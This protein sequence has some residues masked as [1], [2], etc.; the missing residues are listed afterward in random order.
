[1]PRLIYIAGEW[2]QTSGKIAV[3]NP[4]NDAVI[5]EVYLGT[6]DEMEKAISAASEAFIQTKQMEP[7]QKHDILNKVVEG[8]KKRSDEFVDMMIQ[9]VGKPYKFAAAEVQR[10][11]DTFS[12][13]RDAT[14]SLE[15]KFLSLGVTSRSHGKKGIVNRFPIGP[16]AAI[17]PFNFPLNLVAHKLGPAMAV[18]CPIVLKPASKTPITALMLAEIIDKTE[19]PKG[20]LSVIPCSREVGNE[21][22]TDERFKLLTFTGSPSVG[23]KLKSQAGK[24]RVVLE[25]GGNAAV[26]IHKD[27][28][29]ELAASKCAVAGYGAAGQSCISVQRI[30]LHDNI[31]EQFKHIFVE[32]VKKLKIG[33]P[34]DSNTDVGPLITGKDAQRIV[35]WIKEAQEHGATLITGGEEIEHHIVTPALLENLDKNEKVMC[36]EVFGPVVSLQKVASFD[37]GI[38]EINNSVFGLQAGVFTKDLSLAWK[39]FEN[40][41]VGGVMIN[42]VPT[43]RVDSMPYGGIKE[44][45][46]GREGIKYAI[47]DMTEYKIM[48]I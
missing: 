43:F 31:Y 39:A 7:Y 42:E 20:A 28:D 4:Y 8:I 45:G 14:L 17:S 32:E 30:Y 38:L 13:A 6:L 19:W 27:A 18:G 41:D 40:L 2:K 35:A 46:F 21:L 24:K 36:M 16:I 48:I 25:L 3:I 37:E 22:A 29:I 9:E 26:Y 12:L 15:G 11:L 23:W 1:M 5:D 34:S 10:T 44:S 33:D 47:Q